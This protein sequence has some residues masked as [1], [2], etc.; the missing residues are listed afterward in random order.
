MGALIGELVFARLHGA[1]G[2]GELI[3]FLTISI[4]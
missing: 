2:D 4:P 3:L 1:Y